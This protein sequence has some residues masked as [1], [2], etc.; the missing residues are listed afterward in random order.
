[1]T[2][3]RK[4]WLLLPLV[5]VLGLA[6][7]F[8]LAPSQGF[9]PET[10]TVEQAKPQ[11]KSAAA[12]P[13]RELVDALS[14]AFEEASAKV[15]PS[16]VPIF[17]EQVVTVSSPFGMPDDPFRDF[18]GED[19]FRRFFGGP[20]QE[21]RRTQRSLGSGVIVSSDGLI[22]TNNHVVEKADKLSVIIGDDKKTYSAKVVGTDPQTDVAVIRIDAKNL[23]A[24]A[25]GFAE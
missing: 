7:G 19:F 17:A 14:Q 9:A 11:T 20:Q 23:S 24:A 2:G 4:F 13:A 25:S 15:S 3:T 18:F 5:L 10:G 6:I 1:M 16:V 22:L 12:P 8:L 21:Q